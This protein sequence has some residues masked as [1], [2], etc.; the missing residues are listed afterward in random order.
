MIHDG[1]RDMAS[2]VIDITGRLKTKGSKKKNKLTKQAAVTD[3]TSIRQQALA[4]DRRQVKR[5]ILTEFI[6]THVILPGIGLK[7]VSLYD[8]STGGVS[9]DLEKKL[10]AF[11]VNEEISMRIYLNQDSYFPF[12]LKVLNSRF[13]EEEGVYRHGANF[14]QG[15]V[16]E[17]ALFHFVKFLETVSTSLRKDDGDVLVSHLNT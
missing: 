17:E 9:F 6:G 2:N 12:V 7:R 5:T 16:N 14:V 11:K 8:I 4:E 1:G 13:D 3:M 15:S 10:G